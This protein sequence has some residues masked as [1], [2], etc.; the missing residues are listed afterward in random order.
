MTKGDRVTLPP[1]LVALYWIR[2]FKPLLAKNRELPRSPENRSLEEGLSFVRSNGFSRSILVPRRA[3]DRI[4]DWWD[5]GYVRTDDRLLTEQ[6]T[7]EASA[8]LPTLELPPGNLRD[9]LAGTRIHRVLEDVFAAIGLQR[10][11]LSNDQ[12][13]PEWQGPR[14]RRRPPAS[15]PVRSVP[16]DR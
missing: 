5:S 14:D 1:G 15:R 9:L 16:I 8:T 13:I 11:R 3:K 4:I 10:I 2:L 12:R 6:F 7:L